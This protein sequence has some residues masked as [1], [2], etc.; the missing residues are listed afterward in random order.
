MSGVIP[1][2]RPTAESTLR[3]TI[4]RARGA[5]TA[6][7]ALALFALVEALVRWVPMP[8]LVRLLRCRLGLSADDEPTVSGPP[9]TLS[10]T[11]LRQLRW[12]NRIARIWPFS[13][14]PCLRRALVTAHMLRR[15]E[16][17]IRLGTT[18]SGQTLSAHAWVEIDGRPLERVEQYRTFRVAT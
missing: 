11:D 5:V 2:S 4:R 10:A 17:V 18:G 8:R 9:R 6:L 16:P 1:P 15:H 12:T 3:L 7:R 13:H 14:G